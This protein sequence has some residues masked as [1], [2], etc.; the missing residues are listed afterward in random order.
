MTK[1]KVYLIGGFKQKWHEFIV[2][3]KLLE[4]EGFTVI[5]PYFIKGAYTY[6]VEER[7]REMLCLVCPYVYPL[8]GWHL[9]ADAQHDFNYAMYNEKIFLSR[10]ADLR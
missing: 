9:H 3:K 4:S 10:D 1:K 6:D 7:K 8:Q 5:M 2:V